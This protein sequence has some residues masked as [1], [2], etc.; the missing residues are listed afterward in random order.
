MN[1]LKGTIPDGKIFLSAQETG[2][3]EVQNIFSIN[4][5]SDDINRVTY[6]S[7]HFS[8]TDTNLADDDGFL[9]I[10]EDFI[11]EGGYMH[12]HPG[13]VTQNPDTNDIEFSGIDAPSGLVDM[14][15]SLAP[16]N[17]HLSFST[18]FIENPDEVQARIGTIK[19]WSSIIHSAEGEYIRIDEAV[20]P[21][22]FDERTLGVMRSDG[23]YLYDIESKEF[24]DQ[25]ISAAS[26]NQDS[27]SHTDSFAVVATYT[28]NFLVIAGASGSVF[29][30]ELTDG[31][32]LGDLRYELSH[33]GGEYVSPL[34]LSTAQK[35]FGDPVFA[36]VL[37]ENE[38]SVADK[39]VYVQLLTG[40]VI[41]SVRLHK[42]TPGQIDLDF[43]QHSTLGI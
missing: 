27:F 24:G 29:V 16:D 23:I 12:L 18:L 17:D 26:L 36:L 21:T 2:V 30:W 25:I 13:T 11:D 7:I 33:D 1:I 8:Y 41:H 34:S 28:E 37:Q 42:F 10:T 31:F 32:E 20:R 19:N 39:L 35:H 38:D 6:G 43:W 4:T 5:K 9:L 14:G 22:W 3:E 40:E 15:L